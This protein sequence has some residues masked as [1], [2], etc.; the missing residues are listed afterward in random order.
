MTMKK[1]V[2][3]RVEEFYRNQNNGREDDTVPAGKTVPKKRKKFRL[4]RMRLIMT[5]IILLLIAGVGVSVKSVFELH[6]EQKQLEEEQK[7]LKKEKTSL[8]DE[9]KHVKDKEYIEEQA[10]IQLRLIKPGE[11]LYVLDDSKGTDE[12][13]EKN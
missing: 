12:D 5:V 9:L 4:N 10:R 8:D 13:E 11:I 7:Q 1:R 6:A 3:G 2:S